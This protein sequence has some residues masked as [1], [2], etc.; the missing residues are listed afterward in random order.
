MAKQIIAI[1]VRDC[2]KVKSAKTKEQTNTFVISQQTG[3]DF[4]YRQTRHVPR[5]ADLQ[6]QHSHQKKKRKMLET[7][8][9]YSICI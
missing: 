4:Q 2:R 9:I 5:A 3:P 6:G 8:L 1:F 7:L